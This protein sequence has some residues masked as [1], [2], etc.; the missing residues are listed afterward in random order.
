MEICSPMLKMG[1][2]K[3][4]TLK[5]SVDKMYPC[6]KDRSLIYETLTPREQKVIRL[7][8]GLDDA[9][10]RTLE[11]VGREFSV[12]RERIRQIEAK[13]LKKLRQPSRSKKLRDYVDM[14][15]KE[16]VGKYILTLSKADYSYDTYERINVHHLISEET[17]DRIK[18]CLI[19]IK[20]TY[21][22]NEEDLEY[23]CNFKDKIQSYIRK[24]IVKIYLLDQ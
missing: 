23:Y 14:D 11:E 22:L 5:K 9:H 17:V 18:K 15:G 10:P 21:S 12:T 4:A 2:R 13:A 7:R 24:E 8:Y 16:P 6:I 19:E 1:V 20:N 3:A